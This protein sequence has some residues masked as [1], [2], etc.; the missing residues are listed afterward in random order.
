M[1]EN[2]KQ[3]IVYADNYIKK[4]FKI[5]EEFTDH[6]QI[7]AY[8]Y[9]KA[10]LKDISKFCKQFKEDKE[11]NFKYKVYIEDG[12][13]ILDKIKTFKKQTRYKI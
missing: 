8:L 9:K 6:M 5:D 13:I 4:D 2:T 1:G 3:K 10:G 12:E 7:M 11:E